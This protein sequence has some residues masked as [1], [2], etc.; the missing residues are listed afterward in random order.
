MS[1]RSR[2]LAFFV[3]IIFIALLS[4]ATAFV[5][6]LRDYHTQ[7]AKERVS[8]YLAP[9]SVRVGTLAGRGMPPLEIVD[10]IRESAAAANIPI[11]DIRI[12]LVDLEGQVIE[13]TSSGFV[14]ERVQV[15][16]EVVWER[17]NNE[18]WRVQHVKGQDLFMVTSVRFWDLVSNRDPDVASFTAILVVPESNFAG[19]WLELVPTL[20]ISALI[21]MVISAFVAIILSQ[22]ISGPLGKLTRASQEMAQGKYGQVIDVGGEDEI[23]R[24]ATTFNFMSGEVKRSHKMLRDFLANVSHELRT[25]LTSIQGFSQA[26]VDGAITQP[27]EYA[28]SGR[29]INEEANRMRV[30]V[31]DLLRLSKIEAGEISMEKHAFDLREVIQSSVGRCE[32]RARRKNLLLAT[33]LAKLPKVLGN[34]H[35][36]ESV[37][38]ELLDNA[39][40]HTPEGGSITVKAFADGAEPRSLLAKAQRK[41]EPQRVFV[42]VANT[43]SFIPAKDIPHVF[44]RFYQVDAPSSAGGTGLGLAIAREVVQAHSGSIEVSSDPTV[45][46][47]FTV[48]LPAVDGHRL[49]MEGSP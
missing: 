15:P 35:W 23:G 37:F 19:A 41:E 11:L 29:I 46:T 30:L 8:R 39:L 27:A 20:A 34:A 31:D 38:G 44:E 28:Q 32:L 14:G 1:L 24:L 36:L 26:M 47:E 2:L 12:L 5:Y 3:L 43:G 4:A 18:L 16:T 10:S 45:G 48:T 40:R 7:L 9:I 25:P 49:R 22:S 6:L 21:S 13:D 33:Q 17:R 42:S